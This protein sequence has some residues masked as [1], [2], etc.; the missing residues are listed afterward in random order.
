MEVRYK[1]ECAD[2]GAIFT[3]IYPDGL[4]GD[5][6]YSDPLDPKPCECDSQYDLLD[7]LEVEA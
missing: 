7:E 6:S 3:E 2:C 1:V 4:A 5:E